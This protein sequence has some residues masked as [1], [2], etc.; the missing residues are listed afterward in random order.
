MGYFEALAA[1]SFTADSEGRRIFFPWGVLGKGYVIPTEDE[2]ERLRATLVRTYQVLFP[3]TVLLAVLFRSW[4]PWVLFAL[5]SLFVL[6]Y[7]IWVRRATSGWNQSAQRLSLRQSIAN[8]AQHHSRPFL[9]FLFIGGLVFVAGGL[10]LI[11]VHRWYVGIASISLF[12]FG[13]VLFLRMLVVQGR[14]RSA[15]PDQ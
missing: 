7:P 8:Q 14:I 6:G 4:M 10:W 15:N 11:A 12:G 5:P 1:S 3:A 13:A 2:Y 9:W